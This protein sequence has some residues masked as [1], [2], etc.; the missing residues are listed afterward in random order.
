M[1]WFDEKHKLPEEHVIRWAWQSSGFPHDT[2]AIH[3]V[4]TEQALSFHDL[5]GGAPW[6]NFGRTDPTGHVWFR[7]FTR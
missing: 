2:S 5:L 7:C 1:S 6:G 4:E 3:F